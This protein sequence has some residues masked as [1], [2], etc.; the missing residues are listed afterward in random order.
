MKLTQ[1]Q[2]NRLTL[3]I[4]ILL[5][6][7]GIEM[8]QYN[9]CRNSLRGGLVEALEFMEVEVPEDY[10]ADHTEWNKY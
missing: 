8:A 7:E 2:L 1:D 3:K 4:A 5:E 9:E 6:K 10:C